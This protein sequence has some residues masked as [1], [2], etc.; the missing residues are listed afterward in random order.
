M[1][2]S[3]TLGGKLAMDGRPEERRGYHGA[4]RAIGLGKMAAAC[5]EA[6]RG[7]ESSAGPGRAGLRERLCPPCS[8]LPAL[9]GSALPASGRCRALTALLCPALPGPGA[10]P[11]LPARSR[12]AARARPHGSLGPVRDPSSCPAPLCF[13]GWRRLLLFSVT[14]YTCVIQRLNSAA[15]GL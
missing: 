4:G 2:F 3:L 11:A 12:S 6:G 7:G 8:A 5:R 14:F 15:S 9:L 13:R 10:L 1:S